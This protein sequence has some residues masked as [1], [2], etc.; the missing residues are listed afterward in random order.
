MS[1]RNEAVRLATE[2]GVYDDSANEGMVEVQKMLIDALKA[3]IEEY[4]A[5]LR[6][7]EDKIDA[8]AY[9]PIQA[10][11]SEGR[12]WRLASDRVWEIVEVFCIGHLDAPVF[13]LALTYLTHHDAQ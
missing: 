6:E 13:G 7:A 9:R 4:K 3:N 5:A 11:D 12:W 8:A 2:S 1:D 10:P